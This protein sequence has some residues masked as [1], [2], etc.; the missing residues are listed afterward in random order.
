MEDG[1]EILDIVFPYLNVIGAFP[2]VCMASHRMLTSCGIG[3]ME[4][5]TI[6]HEDNVACVV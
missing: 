3:S 5:R 6:I 1:E 4:L 2:Y